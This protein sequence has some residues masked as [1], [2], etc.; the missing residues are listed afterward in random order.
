MILKG[1]KMLRTL[2]ALVIA[3]NLSVGIASENPNKKNHVIVITIDGG[4]AFYLDDP[5]APIPNLR[6]LAAEGVAA[7][8]M[9]V[10]NPAVT[11]PNH[12]TLVT[13]VTPAKHSLLYNGLMEPDAK[14]GLSRNSEATKMQMV[15]VPTVYDLLHKK[16]FTTAGINWPATQKADTLDYCLPDLHRPIPFSTPKLIKE[17]TD[18]KILDETTDAAFLDVG[19]ERREQI[20]ADAASYLLRE[21]QPNLLLLHFLIADGTQHRYGPQGPQAYEALRNVDGHLGE[22]FD[23]VEKAGLRDST[24]IFIVADH[25]FERVMKQIVASTVL[26]RAGLLETDDGKTRVQTIPEGGTLMVYLHSKKT[27]EA[28]RKKV[29]ELFQNQEGIDKI[30]EPNDFKKY[31]YPSP[32]KNPQMCDLVF[33]AKEGYAF[34]GVER[35]QESII[36]TREGGSGSH[37]YLAENPDMNALFIAAGRGIAKGKRIGLV[38]NIDVAPT[39]AFMLGEKFGAD[40]KV[41]K[42]I[43][44]GPQ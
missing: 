43:L 21:H 41:L 15:A 3:A 29:I 12:T 24:T 1:L 36:P 39:V 4:A 44:S 9:K 17:L 26:R 27:R 34:S 7:K 18:A 13:G 37:G 42:Q 10:V 23:A 16:G 20:W 33:S 11:W 25:G 5:K 38:E 30:I 40:G 8:G 2:I 19:G 22:V 28:D 6:K 32:E 31:G 14:G 35:I